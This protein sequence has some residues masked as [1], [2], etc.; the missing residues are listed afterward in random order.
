[1]RYACVIAYDNVESINLK[2]AAKHPDV[3]LKKGEKLVKSLRRTGVFFYV[4]KVAKIEVR[5]VCD[6][7]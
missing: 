6:R 5:E 7:S 3:A 1:M 4:K 2:T